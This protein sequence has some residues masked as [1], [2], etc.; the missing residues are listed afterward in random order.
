MDT[1]KLVYLFGEK[2]ESWK[3]EKNYLSFVTPYLI[4]SKVSHIA[5]EK[6]DL[7]NKVIW[8]MFAGIGADSIYFSKYSKSVISTE[9]NKTTYQH[10][11][12]NI[13]T[14]NCNNITTI[15]SDCCLIDNG[16]DLVFFDP[17]WGSTFISGNT[18]KF[19]EL[20]L[21][22]GVKILDLA[23]KVFDKYKTLI[24][25]SPLKCE[26]FEVLFGSHITSIWT[27]KNQKLKFLLAEKK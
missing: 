8:D 14:F 17:P 20:V 23:E 16:A 21:L 25:K 4:S 10:L 9:I 26:S 27:F 12:D 5:N 13:D 2:H 22:N 19:E 24:I 15:N 6:L 11:C 3:Y 7:S 18:F 1:N